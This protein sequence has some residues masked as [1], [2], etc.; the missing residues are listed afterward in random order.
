MEVSGIH[1]PR[2]SSSPGCLVSICAR[3]EVP[4]S[5]WLPASSTGG[6]KLGVARCIQNVLHRLSSTDRSRSRL[7]AAPSRH[8]QRG[9]AAAMIRRSSSSVR[10]MISNSRCPSRSTVLGADMDA[11]VPCTRQQRLSAEMALPCA[12]SNPFRLIQYHKT[13]VH[14]K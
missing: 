2:H 6:K 12:P 5:R 7:D 11:A 10:L 8:V 9:P 3:V 4:T 14:T 13:S 1:L